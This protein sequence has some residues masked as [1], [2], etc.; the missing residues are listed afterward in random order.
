MSIGV[1]LLLV[2][3]SIIL[4]P[5][6]VK[7][8]VNRLLRREGLKRAVNCSQCEMRADMGNTC[9]SIWIGAR[10]SYRINSFSQVRGSLKKTLTSVCPT[11]CEA[12]FGHM[13]RVDPGRPKV[14]INDEVRKVYIGVFERLR[15]RLEK[16]EG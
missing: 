4:A 8:N 16:Q 3:L 14:L 11:S 7:L 15:S 10:I 6:R 1:L 2:L 9:E 5:I 13:A 12:Y